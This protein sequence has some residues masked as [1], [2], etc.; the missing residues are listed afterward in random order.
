[1]GKIKT[2]IHTYKGSS[3]LNKPTGKKLV[4][5]ENVGTYL[6]GYVT[7]LIIYLLFIGTL[8]PQ[9][10]IKPIKYEWYFAGLV[11]T[12][13]T[14]CINALW[15]IGRTG[16]LSSF[17]YALYSALTKIRIYEL[18]TKLGDSSH[19]IRKNIENHHDYNEYCIEKA[20]HTTRSLQISW[21][22]N[23]VLLLI[24][25]ISALIFEYQ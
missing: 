2:G 4:E 17:R 10:V 11:S 8:V 22:I 14:A 12:I 24:F 16:F 5:Y 9:I 20:E 15:T 18:G 25:S 21:G 1:M 3:T 23:S 7:L 19:Y 13:I 6:T